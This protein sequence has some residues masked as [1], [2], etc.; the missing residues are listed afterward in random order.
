[1]DVE[2]GVGVAHDPAGI[3]VEKTESSRPSQLERGLDDRPEHLTLVLTGI[4]ENDRCPTLPLPTHVDLLF[5]L[6]V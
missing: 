4:G 1:M 5:G 3:G 6:L 2:I